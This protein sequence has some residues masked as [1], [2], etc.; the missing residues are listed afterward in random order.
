MSGTV[1]SNTTWTIASAITALMSDLL[2]IPPSDSAEPRHD[3]DNMIECEVASTTT[4]SGSLIF[5]LSV[6]NH[7]YVRHTS[8]YAYACLALAANSSLRTK[9]PVSQHASI[10]LDFHCNHVMID[11]AKVIDLRLLHKAKTQYDKLA[12]YKCQ[13]NATQLYQS[14]IEIVIVITEQKR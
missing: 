3:A 1:C 9:Q 8:S 10:F 7:L 13:S 14:D 12:K 2:K 6:Q 5:M 4:Q 11:A